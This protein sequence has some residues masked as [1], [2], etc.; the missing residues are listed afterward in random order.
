LPKKD[1][2]SGIQRAEAWMKA[3][4][5]EESTLKRSGMTSQQVDAYGRKVIKGLNFIRVD[6]SNE[7]VVK[8]YLINVC[9]KS[10]EIR[11]YLLD[12][13]TEI[14]TDSSVRT[15]LHGTVALT[16]PPN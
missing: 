8:T 13:L 1:D 2:E 12:H 15:A 16:F 6:S 4:P 5:I 3:N 9:E 10:Y 14:K 11:Q 7:E